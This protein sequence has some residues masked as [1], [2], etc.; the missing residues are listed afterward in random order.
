MKFL[1]GIMLIVLGLAVFFLPY[2]LPAVTDVRVEPEAFERSGQVG[3]AMI[4]VGL[5]LLVLF[6]LRKKKSG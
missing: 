1:P 2:W 6:G 4:G 5:V 3:G